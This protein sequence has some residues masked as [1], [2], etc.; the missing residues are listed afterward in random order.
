MLAVHLAAFFFLSFLHAVVGFDMSRNDNVGH[1]IGSYWGQNSYGATHS[2]VANFQKTLSYY[3]TS[4]S[5]TN[6]FPVAFLTTFFGEGGL[7][8]IDLANI[9]N[10]NDNATFPGTELADCS[11]LASD[12][13]TCQ[14]AGKI[15]TLSIG[16]ASGSV[17]FTS[18]SQAQT[19]ADT[20]W[21]L[22]LGGSNNTRP[23]GSA[24]LDGAGSS[25]GYAAFV[26]RLRSHASSASKQYYV[27][28]APQCPFP[29]ASLGSVINAVG[30][31][32]VYVQFYN[33]YCGL[34]AFSDANDWDFGTWDNWA[35]TTSPNPSSVTLARPRAARR[36]GI[37]HVFELR[38]RVMMWDASQA[39][40]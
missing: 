13:E 31:D 9:C 14:A 21:N 10:S 17:G 3:C 25:T 27:T 28:A 1:A 34:Q 29:D 39:Y 2:D 11:A 8:T 4:D 15:V 19:F 16:G 38:R 12:I 6:T 36:F 20:I 33:N 23:F 7:P 32:A 24:V 26:T 18:D 35:K 22:F 37:L 30:F 40:G 5:V